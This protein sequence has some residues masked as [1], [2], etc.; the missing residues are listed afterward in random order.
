MTTPTLAATSPRHQ[1][2]TANSTL[3]FVLAAMVNDTAHEG[4]HAI[5]ALALGITPT[6]G[7]F[8]VDFDDAGVSVAHKVVVA[9]AGPFFSLVMGLVL[10]VLARS[11]GRGLVRLF[12][13]WL[14]FMGVMN[15]AGYLLISFARGGDTGQ[16]LTLMGAPGWVFIAVSLLGA[17]GFVLLARRFAVEVKRYAA[18]LQQE[19]QLAWFS[20]LIGTPIIIVIAL[21]E[22]ALSAIPV[23]EALLIVAYGVAVGVFAPMQFNF[24]KRARNTYEDLSLKPVNTTGLALAVIGAV[25]L[26]G[27]AGQR[28]LRLG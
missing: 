3:A 27:L 20:W 25:V 7:P 4:A 28:G 12:W 15:F 10:M 9:L 26:I 19:R 17:G 21:V 13:M 2:L 8:S 11:W 23:A 22:T 1:T 5:A 14:S 6:I 18:N 16:A 24:N